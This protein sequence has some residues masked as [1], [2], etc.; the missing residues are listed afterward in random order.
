MKLTMEFNKRSM[1]RAA[2]KTMAAT[3]FLGGVGI[4]STLLAF[5]TLTA[6]LFMGMGILGIFL[7]A[8]PSTVLAVYTVDK[9]DNDIRK[10][11]D[12]KLAGI[13]AKYASV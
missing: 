9:L 12:K 4:S 3:A 10:A 6:P 8:V 13:D 5:G 11:M 7:T 1:E 2:V